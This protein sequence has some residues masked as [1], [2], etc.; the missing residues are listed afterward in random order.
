MKH[1]IYDIQL[2]INH[3]YLIQGEEIVMMDAGVAKKIRQFKKQ[4]KKLN[5]EPQDIKLI[6]VSHAHFDHVGSLADI[7]ECTGAKVAV[8]KLDRENL[9]SGRSEVPKGIS[10]WGR[11]SIK[12]LKPFMKEI[13]VPGV[14]PD[15]IIKDDEYSLEPYGI[16]G[17]IIH[18]PGHTMGSLSIILDS[19]DAF[20]GCM[21]HNMFPFTVR[22]RTPIFAGYPDILNESWKKLMALNPKMIYPGH[23]KSFPAEKM[24]RYIN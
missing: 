7:A 19:G 15:I 17:K 5:I 11:I 1:K 9:E 18:T 12:L 3:C 10:R 13:I 22:P 21:S 14:I 16:K 24:N 2:G 6:V 23:G 4:L 8:H 20:V